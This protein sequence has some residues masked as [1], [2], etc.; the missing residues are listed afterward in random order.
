MKEIWVAGYPSF[1]GGADTELDH[2]IDLWRKHGIA[3]HLVAMFDADEKMKAKCKARGCFTHTYKHT[4][5]RG[6]T[7]VSFCNGEFLRHLPEIMKDKRRPKKVIWF[8][9]MTWTFRDERVAHLRG[10]IDVYGFQT[11]FQ[12]QEITKALGKYGGEFVTLKGYKPY[13]NNT[14]DFNY[15]PPGEHFAMGRI[16]R[17]DPGK[18]SEDMWKIFYKVSAPIPRKY[19]IL[20]WGDKIQEKCGQAPPSLDW[21]TWSP[22]AIP[23]SEFYPQLHCLIH[24]TG[25]SRENC[26]R[27]VPEC[28]AYGVPFIA[29]NAYGIPEIVVNGET[30]FLCESSDEMSYRASQLAF[31]EPLRKKIIYQAHD[32]L[33][34]TLA[35]EQQCIEPWLEVLS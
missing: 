3:V 34:S 28:A 14:I 10:H 12:E 7:V 9:C 26:P 8:N 22:G 1:Y 11:K 4:I 17:D 32:Y 29:E 13:F 15:A 21:Q 5:F 16:S 18:F 33:G 31:D 27:I 6:K 35:N 24:K 23:I 19:F 25:G 2:N 20:G 30:G